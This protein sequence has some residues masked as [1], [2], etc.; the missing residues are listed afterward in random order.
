MQRALIG[1]AFGIGTPPQ[2]PSET[3]P[4]ATYGD[5]HGA[6]WKA[7]SETPRTDVEARETSQYPL[8]HER[9]WVSESTPLLTEATPFFH[10]DLVAALRA[11][12]GNS[13]RQ[14]SRHETPSI[15][16]VDVSIS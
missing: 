11:V 13:E 5:G 3:A 7:H 10:F 16:Q 12:E 6:D 14:L 4:L 9:R 1:G 8:S 2:L 15:K